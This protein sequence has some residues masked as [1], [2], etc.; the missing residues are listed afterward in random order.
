[1]A[2]AEFLQLHLPENAGGRA[3]LEIQ[4]GQGDCIKIGDKINEICDEAYMN[5][6]NWEVL[7]QHYIEKNHKNIDLENFGFDSEA[8]V[9]IL[10]LVERDRVADLDMLYYMLSSVFANPQKLYDYVTEHGDEIPWE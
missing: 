6:Y 1:M 3:W 4:A 8:E 10:N 9:C 5:G 7:L 2:T